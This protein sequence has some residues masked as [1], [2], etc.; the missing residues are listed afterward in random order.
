MRNKSFLRN[1]RN[2]M[3]C[4]FVAS[5]LVLLTTTASTLTCSGVDCAAVIR[6]DKQPLTAG[7]TTTTTTTM[8]LTYDETKY[9]SD[10]NWKGRIPAWIGLDGRMRI[11]SSSHQSHQSLMRRGAVGMTT[12]ANETA[13]SAARDVDDYGVIVPIGPAAAVDDETAPAHVMQEFVP[14]NRRNRLSMTDEQ[15]SSRSSTSQSKDFGSCPISPPILCFVD[16]L[17]PSIVYSDGSDVFSYD[18][19][20]LNENTN[21]NNNNTKYNYTDVDLSPNCYFRDSNNSNYLICNKTAADDTIPQPLPDILDGFEM[22]QTSLRYIRSTDFTGMEV[23][24]LIL[25]ENNIRGISL[26]TFE[27]VRGVQKLSLERNQIR[28]VFWESFQGLDSLLILSLRGNHINLTS[29]GTTQPVELPSSN[30]IQRNNA[31]NNN[32]I[33]NSDNSPLLPSLKYLNLAE[34]PL[35]HLNEFVFWQLTDSPIEELNLQSCNLN[36]IHQGKLIISKLNELT[37]ASSRH[38]L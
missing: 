20:G 10:P 23:T 31:P 9:L 14:S 28:T 11:P 26:N 17:T 36:F 2:T 12:W 3:C 37:M 22:R 25:D 16:F 19:W 30:L 5:F 13:L 35:G 38:R 1:T 34:N 29:A 27:D 7:P 33:L 21:S 8:K 32:N 15:R 4:H 24:S 18:L 6:E